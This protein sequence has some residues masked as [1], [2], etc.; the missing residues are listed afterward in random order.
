MGRGARRTGTR[1][2]L[3]VQVLDWRFT[4]G[5][6][7]VSIRESRFTGKAAEQAPPSIRTN[8]NFGFYSFRRMS[9]SFPDDSGEREV[10]C[11]ISFLPPIS[12]L[13]D[14]DSRSKVVR[15]SARSL[16]KDL[17]DRVPK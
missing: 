4:K 1:V 2:D 6:T 12:G 11:V 10:S 7:R 15:P 16:T 5:T 13:P 9:R 17:S 14:S 8:L 3:Q